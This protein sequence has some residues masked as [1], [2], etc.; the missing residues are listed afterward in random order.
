MK[1]SGDLDLLRGTFSSVARYSGQSSGQFCWMTDFNPAENGRKPLPPELVEEAGRLLAT[2][3]AQY[4]LALKESECGVVPEVFSSPEDLAQAVQGPKYPLAKTFWRFMRAMPQGTKAA[5][6]CRHCDWRAL[7]EQKNMNQYEG[8]EVLCLTFPCDARQAHDCSCANPG[9][10]AE[11]KS[12][13]DALS[14]DLLRTLSDPNRADVW[15]SHM[16]RCIK[17]FGCRNACPICVCP[18]CRLE[19]EIFVPP[20]ILPPPP[21]PWHLCRALHVAD[22]CVG[23]GACQDACPAGIPL[24]AIH[25]AL[26][27]RLHAEDGYLSGYKQLS[28][29]N[30]PMTAEGPCGGPPPSWPNFTGRND[31]SAPPTSSKPEEQR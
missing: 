9:L 11:K 8:Q 7:E 19:D 27:R 6:A 17:C 22:R 28:P 23:C 30:A 3:Q 2:G 25:N 13:A 10:H 12:P 29:L 5:L 31:V 4:V 14:P 24:L 18:T 21:L 26:A 16:Q 15:L 20:G 1:D